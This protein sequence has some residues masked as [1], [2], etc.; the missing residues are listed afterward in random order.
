ML[1]QSN[2]NNSTDGNNQCTIPATWGLHY[3]AE[4]WHALDIETGEQLYL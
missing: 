2:I 1:V 3:A 4:Q